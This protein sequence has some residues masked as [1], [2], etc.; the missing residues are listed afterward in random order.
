MKSGD[1]VKISGFYGIIN[2]PQSKMIKGEE[3]LYL[4]KDS[5]FPTLLT[6]HQVVTWKL[7]AENQYES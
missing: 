1:T 2:V 3:C 7:F 4:D 5:T 6:T